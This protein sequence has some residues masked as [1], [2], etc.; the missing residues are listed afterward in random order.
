MDREK[1][2][3]SI[4]GNK[5][6]K[7]LEISSRSPEL[8][9]NFYHDLENYLGEEIEGELLKDFYFSTL[10]INLEKEKEKDILNFI[11]SFIKIKIHERR[12]DTI[13]NNKG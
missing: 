3:Y 1:I 10:F 7:K 5:E 12:S 2:L 11:E 6:I 13:G 8:L 4:T 9:E